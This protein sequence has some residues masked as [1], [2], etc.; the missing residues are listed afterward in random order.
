MVLL[1]QGINDVRDLISAAINTGQAG[2]DSTPA[3]DDQTDLLAPV[4]NTNNAV[5][6]V[7]S[8]KTIKITHTVSS[9]EADGEDLV[10]WITD[11]AS[12]AAMRVVSNTISKDT[13]HQVDHI[14]TLTLTQ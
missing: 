2:T 1:N 13:D 11:I 14:W 12:V 7:T 3:Q 9:V 10:E 8:D 4:A 5:T 6:V